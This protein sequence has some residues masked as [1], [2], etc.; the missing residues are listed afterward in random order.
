[1]SLSLFRGLSSVTGKAS[2]N[3]PG[4]GKAAEEGLISLNTNLI[5]QPFVVFLYCIVL[6]LSFVGVCFILSCHNWN[7]CCGS[8]EKGWWKAMSQLPRCTRWIILLLLVII[9]KETKHPCTVGPNDLAL[10]YCEQCD[11][12]NYFCFLLPGKLTMITK[13]KE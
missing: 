4:T 8:K 3:L 1:M 10:I 7:I 9:S 2:R 5:Q 6:V 11:C 13:S 12:S